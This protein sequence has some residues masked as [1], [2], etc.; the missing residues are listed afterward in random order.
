MIGYV[1]QCYSPHLPHSLLHQLSPQ[2]SLHLCL[3]SFTEKIF[4]NIIFLDPI[5]LSSVIQSCPTLCDSM[6]RSMPGLPVHHQLLESTQ[7]HVHWDGD[8]IKPSHPLSSTSALN[9]SQHLGLFKLVSCSR[10]PKYWSFSFSICPS[11]EHLGL[12]SFR[13]DWLGLLV[14]Q[15][16]LKSLLLHHSSKH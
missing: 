7:T 5:H 16:T 11:N 8:A 12:I 3:Y 9:H 10:W 4:I 2:L 14:I 6:N 1:C 15:G 13:V